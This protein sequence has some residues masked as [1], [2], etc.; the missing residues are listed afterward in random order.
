MMKNIQYILL[1]IF[2]S[3]GLQP[4]IVQAL[5]RGC[6][7]SIAYTITKIEDVNGDICGGS[8]Y[9]PFPTQFGYQTAVLMD[10]KGKCVGKGQANSVCR[11]KARD[12]A[13][14]CA[15]AIWDTG[16][17]S[18]PLVNQKCGPNS[19]AHIRQWAPGV[20][21]QDQ[22]RIFEDRF[23]DIKK[24]IQYQ[25]C[26]VDRP[27]A[28]NVW[29]SVHYNTDSYTTYT[30][31]GS[32]RQR[33]NAN[34]AC[35]SHKTLDSELRLDCIQASA[36]GLCGE[37]YVRDAS[38]VT[39]TCTSKP[40]SSSPAEQKRSDQPKAKT[41]KT[42]STTSASHADI[43]KELDKKKKKNA[44]N[45]P[46]RTNP[47]DPLIEVQSKLRYRALLN[48]G[49]KV[50]FI[51]QPR[52][53]ADFLTYGE[54]LTT[55]RGMRLM[56][57]ETKFVAGG[58]Y[59]IGLWEK[60]SGTS[61]FKQSLPVTDFNKLHKKNKQKG[62]QLADFELVR[63]KGAYQVVSLWKP[64]NTQEQ[65]SPSMDASALKSRNAVLKEKNRYPVDIEVRV[66]KG[67]I[68][69]AALWREGRRVQFMPHMT[70]AAFRATR[71]ELVSRGMKAVDIEFVKKG[72]EQYITALWTN[73]EGPTSVSKPRKY[74]AFK[75]FIDTKD[76][77]F[78]EDLEIQIK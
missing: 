30:I 6:H 66:E 7:G 25:T 26:C 56:D 31:I 17:G 34:D 55:T 61:L 48:K 16:G 62:L 32:S 46:T 18:G 70:M 43:Q 57:F 65:F 1:T 28:L 54:Q 47:V 5:E 73:G 59:Y 14:K 2:I 68:R 4:A 8:S 19:N 71:D 58:L 44:K 13:Q 60:G 72:G 20:N 3:L 33:S 37:P 36:E 75:D 39:Q 29:V 78:I 10:G 9:V 63:K 35:Y 69:Y 41:S 40:P 74:E 53:F 38:T 67:E 45:N 64:G 42:T 51:S 77:L 49:Q 12:A 21:L 22:A 27:E 50:Q 24:I 52:L 11:K 23:G 76:T 15:Q